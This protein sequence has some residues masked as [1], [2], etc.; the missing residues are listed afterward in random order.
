LS[1]NTPDRSEQKSV[2]ADILD[3]VRDGNWF[4]FVAV[5]AHEQI[6]NVEVIVSPEIDA[7]LNLEVAL[8]AAK[9]VSQVAEVV[10]VLV[11]LLHKFRVEISFKIGDIRLD[12]RGIA[13]LL[14]FEENHT[15]S[16]HSRR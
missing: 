7:R 5:L 4:I 16:R 15:A 9:F 1:S 8:G 2:H 3:V 14:G 13:K 10:H 6:E 11:N 12:Q